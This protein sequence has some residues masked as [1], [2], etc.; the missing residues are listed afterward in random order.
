MVIF[1]FFVDQFLALSAGI[2]YRSG[3]LHL[4]RADSGGKVTF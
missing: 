3:V 1:L 2:K 4:K